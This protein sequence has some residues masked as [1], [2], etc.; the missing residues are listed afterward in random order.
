MHEMVNIGYVCGLINGSVIVLIY[1]PEEIYRITMIFR[2]KG[3]SYNIVSR[4]AN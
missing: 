1:L 3:S 4:I 2:K